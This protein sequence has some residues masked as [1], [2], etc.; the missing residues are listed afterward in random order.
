MPTIKDI[1]G[2]QFGRWTALGIQG[3]RKRSTMWLCRCDCGTERAVSSGQLIAGRSQ[4]C[5]CLA[6]EKSRLRVQTHGLS[7]SRIF[8]IWNTMLQ[9]C[10][11]PKNKKF[12][13]YGGRGIG[14]C[15]EWRTNFVVF[16]NYMGHAPPGMS[17]DRIN[18]DGDY[19]PGNVRWASKKDQSNNRRP[20]RRS[21]PVD[22]EGSPAQEPR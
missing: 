4:S 14:V 5:G 8:W 7:S 20:K 9:R 10:Y 18:N 3:R 19:E 12:K 17:L 1:T 13:D 11:N 16:Y 15:T 22:A 2:L 6:R 21:L